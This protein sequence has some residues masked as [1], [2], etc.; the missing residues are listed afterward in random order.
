MAQTQSIR[1]K[2]VATL[3]PASDTPK[4]IAEL[5]RAGVDVFRLN[6][7]HANH[8]WHRQTIRT[9][10]K[11]AKQADRA[12]AVLADLQGPRIRVADIPGGPMH[13]RPGVKV[14][15]IPAPGVAKSGQ[16][17]VT[18]T[19][20][21]QDVHKGEAILLD[22]GTMELTVE[23]K[24]ADRIVARV[25]YGGL[26]RPFK[27]I[28][29]PG[30]KV[31]APS[32]TE[33]DLRDLD[34]AIEEKVDW[35]GLS[36]VRRA[37][38][39]V[40][41]KARIHLAKSKAKVVAKIERGDAIEDLDRIL[42]ATDAVMVARGDLGVEMGAAE[43]PILQKKIIRRAIELERPVITA[44]QM[45]D[46]MTENPR[47]TRAEAS[48][49]ANAILDGTDAIMLSGE[50][51]RGKYPAQTVLTARRIASRVESELLSKIQMPTP[52]AHALEGKASVDEA[53]VLAG[54]MAAIA[55]GAKFIVPFT[56][57]GRTAVLVASNRVPIPIMTF[58][59]HQETYQRVALY[60]GT[61]VALIPKAR[62]LNQ[63]Y[64]TA[65]RWM[66]KQKLV[67][68]GDRVLLV[69]GIGLVAGAT[70]TMRV[71][72]IG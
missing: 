55:A 63:M 8:D 59:F 62:S 37:E 69:S 28:N 10:R 14:T 21:A 47:P 27:G 2:I 52:H 15:M 22:D 71:H 6:M 9:I 24:S 64:D 53:A 20:F 61:R 29:L 68:K 50:T 17:P 34:L 32:L 46:S 1:T 18:Y 41:L 51:A 42:V 36:F 49:V 13:L 57:T 3:G 58:T 33:K 12:I 35:I 4:V 65:E 26:L 30:S 5:I 56:E 70:N 54:T 38:D 43:V 44:T 19:R 67:K 39:V 45:L 66:K 72:E 16:I 25:R 60:W 7:S 31:S 11:L 23:S 40:R 48:D